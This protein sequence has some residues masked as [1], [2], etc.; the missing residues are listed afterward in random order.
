NELSRALHAHGL[1]A[2]IPRRRVAAHRPLY[3]R[4]R[5]PRDRRGISPRAATDSRRLLREPRHRPAS[6]RSRHWTPGDVTETGSRLTPQP[7]NALATSYHS[8]GTVFSSEVAS[9]SETST[10]ASPFRATMRP[11]EPARTRSA[12]LRP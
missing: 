4:A 9:S 12:A 2:R 1:A 5:S 8:G 11:H 3:G 7:K 6:R 10:I